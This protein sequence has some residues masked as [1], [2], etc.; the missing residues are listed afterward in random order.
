MLHMP[1]G[2]PSARCLDTESDSTARH[3]CSS[4]GRDHWSCFLHVFWTERSDRNS[5][6]LVVRVRTV[7]HHR[8][9][10]ERVLGTVLASYSVGRTDGTN[11]PIRIQTARGDT[12]NDKHTSRPCSLP[13][14]THCRTRNTYTTRHVHVHVHVPRL[15]YTIHL[16]SKV[17]TR[18]RRREYRAYRTHVHVHVHVHVVDA[19]MHV[20]TPIPTREMQQRADKTAQHARVLGPSRDALS[21]Y[22][23]LGIRVLGI[24]ISGCLGPSRDAW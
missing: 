10:T 19:H 13:T 11:A 14:A 21:G 4:S 15:R 24:R 5:V 17:Q 22:A 12:T 6:L 20:P 8:S 1:D 16:P 9:C 18:H 7:L 23:S 3:R 2:L